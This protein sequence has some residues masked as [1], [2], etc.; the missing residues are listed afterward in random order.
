MN[1]V[2]RFLGVLLVARLAAR[3]PGPLARL[4]TAVVLVVV[5]L[6]PVWGVT[7]ERIGMGDVFLVYWI[8][9]VV[10]WACG[11]V[12]TATAEGP[13][14]G[15]VAVTTNGVPGDMS[16]AKFFALH[17]GIFTL[18]HGVFAII[19][20]ALV[21]LKGGLGQVVLLS[22]AIT[23]SHLFSLGVNWFGRDERKV[24]SP[25]HGDV[26]AVPA[27]ARPARRDHHRVR[28]RARRAGARR[29][30]PTDQVTA[31]AVLCVMKTLVD[32]GFH[33][34]AAP[35][36]ARSSAGAGCTA[37]RAAS[38]IGRGRPAGCTMVPMTD[39][40]T[41]PTEQTV[42]ARLVAA[43]SSPLAATGS[44]SWRWRPVASRSAPPSSSPWACSRR[45]PRAWTCPSR[46]PG[47]SSPRTR[48]AS[49]SARRSWRSSAPGGRGGG[50]WSR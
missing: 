30:R 14:K 39:V 43:R 46:P 32:L 20:A 28:H 34:L 50:C 12:R 5:N 36:G 17:Y 6:L 38:G 13:G 10:V 16:S 2:L 7:T 40:T 15:T 48:S 37:T 35:L 26:R 23:A 3:L 21:G 33:V 31:V 44:R 41:D 25:G 4:A 27:D 1:T 47:T 49:S 22:L 45:S 9:N 8:E 11:I 29:E 19:M 18:V 42:E 24:V